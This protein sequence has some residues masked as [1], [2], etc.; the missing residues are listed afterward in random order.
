MARRTET[1]TLLVTKQDANNW[2]AVSLERC[3]VG[4]G[5]TIKEAVGDWVKSILAE[6]QVDLAVLNNPPEKVLIRIGK[7]PEIYW[8]MFKEGW[9]LRLQNQKKVEIIPIQKYLKAD[10]LKEVETIPSVRELRVG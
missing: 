8:E 7:V 2:A 4:G 6:M 10:K 1:W 3:I 9:P 5:T